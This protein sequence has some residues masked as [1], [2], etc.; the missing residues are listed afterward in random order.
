[1]KVVKST[2][3]Q[4]TQK[5]LRRASLLGL[6]GK[7]AS[8]KMKN[9][10]II[11]D[12]MKHET[13]SS[14]PDTTSIH[15]VS[16]TSG[17]VSTYETIDPGQAPSEIK[18][19]SRIR[20][21]MK[22]SS[23]SSSASKDPTIKLIQS[24]IIGNRYIIHTPFGE[25]EIVYADYTASGRSLK[26]IEDYMVN[27]VS[28]TYANTHT[29]ASA[30]GAQTT[31]LREESRD[32][33]RKAINA[34]KDE[35]AVL[36]TGAGST[37][38]IDKIFRVMGLGIPEYAEKKWNL[39]SHIPENER[40]VVFISHFEHHSNELM[41]R[42]S[43]ARCVVIREGRDGTPD[44]AHLNSELLKYKNANVPLIGSFSA[45]SNVTGIKAPVRSICKIL[46]RHGA[47]AFIDYA[48]VGAYV[49]I[50]IKGTQGQY[51]E[52]EEDG[53]IDAAFMSPHKYIGGP[54]SAGLLAARRKLF[55]KAF[56]IETNNA[57]CPGGGTVAYV[58]RKGHMYS[59]DIE[60][61]EDSGTPGILQSIR[62][63]LVFKV[64]DMVGSKTIE[65]LDSVHA[66]MALQS[67]RTNRNI[68]LIGA[69][70]I[71][72]QMPTRRVSIFSFNI[73]SP[74]PTSVWQHDDVKTSKS[75][76]KVVAGAINDYARM[77]AL[78]SDTDLVPLHYNF[79][80]ALLNDVY[81]IQGRG[82]CSCAGPYGSDLFNFDT[83]D[84]EKEAKM[85]NIFGT[86]G[87]LK[88]GWARI[89]FNYFISMYEA[90]FIVDAVTQIAN[91]GWMLLPLYVQDWS[92]GQFF[93]HSLLD[94]VTGKKMKNKTQ[95]LSSLFSIHDI[96]LVPSDPAS[97]NDDDLK[98]SF[99]KPKC[100][101]GVRSRS[102]YRQVLSDAKKMYKKLSQRSV[103]SAPRGHVRDF[104]SELSPDIN[105]DDI[106][107]LLPSEAERRLRE[108][109]KE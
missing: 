2:S 52:G 60:H 88:P 70:R 48:G 67:W 50:D 7:A 23:S 49:N 37:G 87:A 5:P 66:T 1:M 55:Q 40:P 42:E 45:G 106:W 74:I 97:N 101:D 108:M 58:S 3:N 78:E 103:S 84:D 102:S 9:D 75:Y 18:M 34:P 16:S 104:M 47:Y 96:N 83:L 59:G 26:L 80:I 82:G 41:W 21:S 39:S 11:G 33:I 62:T 93:H 72:Y 13:S 63:G 8:T 17:S 44:L 105:R 29:E 100:V 24:N 25:K 53:S 22:S 65:S 64:K 35:Y 94:P 51:G 107:W 95:T 46:H 90:S 27:V 28:P 73:L 30:T 91:Y 76:S 99:P 15:V 69:D 4:Q 79:V 77:G 38:A 86:H 56:D 85:L 10:K 71:S 36:F 68:S 43:V 61:R 81:G 109:M 32:F 12:E 14:S 54:G 92:S 98:V 6:M 20:R 89:N 31:H 57:T 19:R